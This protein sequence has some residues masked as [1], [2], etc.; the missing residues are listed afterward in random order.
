MCIIQVS[1]ISALSPTLVES[2]QFGHR[3]G[4]F[5]GAVADRKGFLFS[6]DCALLGQLKLI[7]ETDDPCTDT[8]AAAAPLSLKRSKVAVR[9]ETAPTASSFAAVPF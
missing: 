1:H 9:H 8:P 6:R 4:A 7:S 5:T 3:R 2:E